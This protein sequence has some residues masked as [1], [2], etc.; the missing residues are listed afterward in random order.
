MDQKRLLLTAGAQ[1]MI[2]PVKGGFHAVHGGSAQKPGGHQNQRIGTGVHIE[3]IEPSIEP[4]K[5]D[6]VI[7]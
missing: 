5:N 3:I 6:H 1:C 2:C 4:C 7:C